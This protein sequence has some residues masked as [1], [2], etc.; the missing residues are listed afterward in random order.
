M[1]ACRQRLC[2][3]DVAHAVYD[4]IQRQRAYR[5]QPSASASAAHTPRTV[6]LTLQSLAASLAFAET[7]TMR[8]LLQ[9]PHPHAPR[10]VTLGVQPQ[11]AYS[12]VRCAV[13]GRLIIARPPPTAPLLATLAAA[14]SDALGCADTLLIAHLLAPASVNASTGGVQRPRPAAD[15]FDAAALAGQPGTAVRDADVPL[16]QLLPLRNFCAGEIVAVC[17]DD[18][19]IVAPV[20]AASRV[21]S[22]A[23]VAAAEA[24]QARALAASSSGAGATTDAAAAATAAA[25]AADSAADSA[26]AMT[27]SLQQHAGTGTGDAAA[28]FAQHAQQAQR[29]FMLARVAAD[30]SPPADAIVY[31]VRLETAPGTVHP[32]PSTCIYTFSGDADPGAGSLSSVAH[33]PRAD[34][35]ASGRS[36][37]AA[38]VLQVDVPRAAAVTRGDAPVQGGDGASVVGALRVAGGHAAQAAGALAQ[39]LSAAG[40]PLDLE[41]R[42][43]VER[44]M[45]LRSEAA[46]S[47]A[48]AQDSQVRTFASFAYL[49]LSLSVQRWADARFGVVQAA[50]D[51]KNVQL[52]ELRQT[53]TCGICFTEPISACFPNCGHLA[54]WTCAEH[55]DSRCPLCRKR[56]HPLRLYQS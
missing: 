13:T 5:A 21:P 41:R 43:L 6:A 35:A 39:M 23:L 51:E 29:R 54:C 52:E 17:V 46:V 20:S 15:L 10:D 1:R 12:A 44:C 36:S 7:C 27:A 37:G 11:R 8:L 53:W 45:D 2:S 22:G 47:A 24:R 26:A 14:V 50:V 34:A 40:L 38:S 16:L 31:S 30:A 32:Y 49:C 55:C 4:A 19:S 18:T 28:V 3:S 48:R 9:P 25:R 56:S 33:L 42:E